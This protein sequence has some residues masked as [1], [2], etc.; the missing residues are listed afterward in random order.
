VQVQGRS[1]AAIFQLGGTTTN[2]LVGEP[3]GASGWRLQSA[4]GDSVVI[5]RQGQQRQV[6]I[7][8]DGP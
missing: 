8:T 3:I 2:V 1:G 7:S 5:E 4:S 6:S